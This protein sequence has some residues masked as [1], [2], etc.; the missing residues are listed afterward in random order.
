MNFHCLTWTCW[1]IP[2]LVTQRSLLWTVFSCYNHI[3]MHPWDA[4]NIAFR[5][6]MGNFH[7]NVMLWGLKNVAATYQ[8]A[9]NA[10][11]H[12]MLHN[13]LEYFVDDIVVNCK[14]IDNHVNDLRESLWKIQTFKLRKKVLEC[15]F[16]VY[17]MESFLDSL[18][19]ENELTSIWPK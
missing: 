4:G 12:D 15:T 10:I 16:L 18:C 5:I 19:V 3:K 13:S 14:E 8:W 6:T 2:L 11:F 9:T 17:L 7:Y 1:V